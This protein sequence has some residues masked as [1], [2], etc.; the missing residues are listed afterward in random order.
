VEEYLARRPHSGSSHYLEHVVGYPSP[1]ISNNMLELLDRYFGPRFYDEPMD[2]EI[3][4]RI[5]R[6][7]DEELW[8]THERRRERLV[9]YARDRIRQEMRRNGVRETQLY[10][11]E[12]ALSPSTLTISFARRFA[13]YKRGN[14]L[15]RD[16]ER[17]LRLI[18]DNDRPVQLIFAGKAHPHDIPGKELIREIVH[19]SRKPEVRARLVFLEDYDMT[20]SRYLT[21]GS[22]LWLNTPRR[23][24]EASGTSGMKAGVN[25]VLNCSVLDGWWAEAYSPDYGWA[26]GKGES[27][28]DEELQDDI[29]SKALY[30]LLER[31]II[32]LFYNRGRDGLPREWIKRMKAS[33]REIGREMSSH[34]MLMEYAN[35]FYLPALENYRELEAG[36]FSEARELSAYLAKIRSAW[37]SVSIRSISS[38]NRPIMERGDKVTVKADVSLGSLSPKDVCVE[39]Y[40][41]AISSQGDFVAPARSEMEAVTN[42]GDLW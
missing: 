12:D 17:L 16:P 11:A 19:F 20:M 31:E 8:R 14:L 39:L 21:S 23:P 7:S 9:V 32:P 41:G 22:D 33:I 18:S 26:I 1:W 6:I 10:R 24:L 37:H 40:H 15:L 13:T 4:K 27:Y 25:G 3:W 34:R 30:D 36:G 28:E 29:E 2:M 42:T 38:D 5:D 35:R